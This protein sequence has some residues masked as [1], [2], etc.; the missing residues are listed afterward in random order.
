MAQVYPETPAQKG[1]IRP[2]DVI[3]DI[4]GQAIDS[5][6][7][8][9][10]VVERLK[11]GESYAVTI[12]RDG[13]RQSIDVRL[14]AMPGDFGRDAMAAAPEESSEPS[15][16]SASSAKL[17]ID[18]TDLT[19]EVRRQLRLEESLS[20]VLV[21]SAD[22]QGAAYAAG[23]RTGQIIQRVGTTEVTSVAEFETALSNAS[24][25]DGILLFVRTSAGSRFLVVHPNE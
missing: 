16:R 20:G 3:F 13:K 18:V 17:G 12:L 10:G 15:P 8:L 14:E 2:G 24:G 21:K 25:E 7:R 11:I 19:A 23:V 1:G 4:N 5:G 6:V 22:P 9:Q